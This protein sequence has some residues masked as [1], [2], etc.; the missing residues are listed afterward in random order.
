[1][2]VLVVD[3]NATNRRI[4]EELLSNWSMRP[5]PV[6]SGQEALSAL[7]QSLVDGVPFSLVL[8]DAQMP[9][10]DGFAVAA[11]IQH[12]PGL[13]Q[14]H[15]VMLTSAGLPGEMLSCQGLGIDACQ[16]KPIKQSELLNTILTVLGRKPRSVAPL[17]SITSPTPV[18][19]SLTILLAEDNIVNQQ[20]TRRVLE[21]LGHRV[22][23]ANNGREALEIL[24]RKPFDLVLMDVQ[25]PEMD[26]FEATR[27]IRQR[28]AQTGQHLPILAMTAHALKG[29][30][31]RCLDAGMD[32]Y[33]AKPIRAAQLVQAIDS[34]L[35]SRA[36]VRSESHPP[37]ALEEIFDRAEALERTGADLGLL[38]ELAEVFLESSPGQ[39]A[40]VRDA[41]A[42][43]DVQ[44]L[45]RAAHSLKGSSAAIGARETSSAA[46]RLEKMAGAGDLIQAEAACAALELAL[47]RLKPVLVEIAGEGKIRNPHT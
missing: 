9:G 37:L 4:L 19:S 32:D 15:V 26:G 44:A 21:R 43:R 41:L 3:D 10:M 17:S 25:M 18:L 16:M 7:A 29:D 20:L 8:L 30:R 5:T 28:E 36:K 47:E 1:L 23:V 33:V 13:A 39:L 38:R 14:T 45:H 34:L 12:H 24:P 11:E 6:A 2:P 31:E 42:R 22:V 40:A 35:S 27:A 46:E